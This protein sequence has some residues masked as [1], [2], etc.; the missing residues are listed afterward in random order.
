MS[1]SQNAGASSRTWAIETHGVTK[2]FDTALAVR[3]LDLT[4]AAGERV[5]LFGQNGAGKTTVIKLLAGVLHPTAGSIRV[6]GRRPYG[7][8]AAV[9]RLIGLV[10][11]QSYLYEELSARENLLFYARLYGLKQPETHVDVALENVGMARRA[12][13]TVRTLSRGMQQRIALARAIV[14]NPS[15]LLLDEPDTGLDPS[16]RERLADLLANQRPDLTV[17]IATH[18]LEM[19]MTLCSR[20]VILR[21]GYLVYDSQRKEESNAPSPEKFRRFIDGSNGD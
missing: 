15:I 17:L 14:H 13:D 2:S 11:H 16:A 3:K 12:N 8:G 19:G 20:S 5:A 6:W 9:R 1:V 18:N 7:P 21:D 10:S 4:V